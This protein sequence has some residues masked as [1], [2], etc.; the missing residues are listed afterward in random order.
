MSK[1]RVGLRVLTELGLYGI[2][3][4]RDE[5]FKMLS[6]T[7]TN[8]TTCDKVSASGGIRILTVFPQDDFFG[9]VRR[10]EVIIDE[11]SVISSSV[12]LNS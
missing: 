6:S 7:L 2:I 5:A 11:Y 1:F 3:G 8:I 12:F 10:K 9:Q 4:N